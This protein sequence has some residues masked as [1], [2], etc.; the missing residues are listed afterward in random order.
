MLRGSRR[1]RR[2]PGCG[3]SGDRRRRCRRSSCSERSRPVPSNWPAPA[4]LGAEAEFVFHFRRGHRTE[5]EQQGERRDEG[6]GEQ[7]RRA[8]RGV[9][10]QFLH[11]SLALSSEFPSLSAPPPRGYAACRV[12]SSWIR[13]STAGEPCCGSTMPF[14]PVI[15]DLRLLGFSTERSAV[16]QQALLA[17]LQIQH[18]LF[19][20]HVRDRGEVGTE[21]A[22]ARGVD[23]RRQLDVDLALRDPRR[24]REGDCWRSAGRPRPH[25]RVEQRRRGARGTEPRA[26]RACV[27]RRTAPGCRRLPMWEL[28]SSSPVGSVTETR[29]ELASPGLVLRTAWIAGWPRR[30]SPPQ[31]QVASARSPGRVQ[32]ATWKGAA[33]WRRRPAS[34][35]M[36]RHHRE[37]LAVGG[38]EREVRPVEIDLDRSA[39]AAACPRDLGSGSETAVTCASSGR[40][41]RRP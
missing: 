35:Q 33:G 26:L 6:R 30:L 27:R 3:C 38:V 36:S 29:R 22:A 23:P 19:D 32:F 39:S 40:R 12:A 31:A 20:R 41:R 14:W 28:S 25:R 34:P 21:A 8:T 11:R 10:D 7:P 16:L 17:A 18:E 37:R 9:C 2:T 13:R 4:P 24:G 5:G 1:L 15:V